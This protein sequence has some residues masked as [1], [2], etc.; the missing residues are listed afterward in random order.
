MSKI[1]EIIVKNIF[2]CEY[3]DAENCD[4]DCYA[5]KENLKKELKSEIMKC[6]DFFVIEICMDCDHFFGDKCALNNTKSEVK[7]NRDI[8]DVYIQELKQKLEKLFGEGE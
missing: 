5:D 4:G 7:C 6:L 1:D 2:I 8:V 3:D